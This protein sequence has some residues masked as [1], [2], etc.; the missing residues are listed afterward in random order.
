MVHQP[1]FCNSLLAFGR[2]AFRFTDQTSAVMN[3][4]LANGSLAVVTQ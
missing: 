2:V 4:R 3:K 1:G